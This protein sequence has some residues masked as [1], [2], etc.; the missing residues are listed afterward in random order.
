MSLDARSDPHTVYATVLRG[1]GLT[2]SELPPPHDGEGEVTPEGVGR[3][4]VAAGTTDPY[5]RLLES[6]AHSE[7]GVAA[8]RHYWSEAP[9]QHLGPVLSAFGYEFGLKTKPD[10]DGRTVAAVLRTDATVQRTTFTYPED[11]DG[12]D[13]YP[14]LVHAI[15]QR[16][17]P[18]AGPTFVRLADDGDAW[19]FAL[20]ERWRLAELQER[21]GDRI[22]VFGE[23]LLAA[24][25]P[26]D[27]AGEGDRPGDVGTVSVPTAPLDDAFEQ[28]R[29]DAVTDPVAGAES[30][31]LGVDLDR[32]SSAALRSADAALSG[33][34]GADAT[35]GSADGS[36]ADG[37]D[38]DGDDTLWS[39]DE[40]DGTASERPRK[41]YAGPE[42]ADSGP[43]SE[44]VSDRGRFVPSDP[45]E[46]GLDA[47]PTGDTGTQESAGGTGDGG[48]GRHVADDADSVADLPE[49]VTLD[50]S[51]A[52]RARGE[53]VPFVADDPDATVLGDDID[54]GPL[55]DA[56]D[57]SGS[58]FGRQE[59]GEGDANDGA[60]TTDGASDSG[61]GP[62]GA[63]VAATDAG[64]DDG[65][66][67]A[68]TPLSQQV[69]STL[70]EGGDSSVTTAESASASES[71]TADATGTRDGAEDDS[72]SNEHVPR[73]WSGDDADTAER[74]DGDVL[75]A[76][77]EWIE[78]E[79]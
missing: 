74:A 54:D 45:P 18:E 16:L 52:T 51:H 2:R 13:A 9:A 22:E 10:G 14:A 3:D 8:P 70:N 29:R 48:S 37:A 60:A 73:E 72:V 50:R 63:A 23:P 77:T 25:Q 31:D 38:P 15:E 39:T 44:P 55:S 79:R 12:P 67:S 36:T 75:S 53:G 28:V 42:D 26:A 33:E 35:A 65:A 59:E 43:E 1:F 61:S 58:V 47:A 19:R 41:R 49:S 34:R 30:I 62:D 6:L 57:D 56:A 40:T 71:G 4:L 66:E 11:G 64:R 69:A 68:E 76:I 5:D 21:F 20:V 24:Y 7:H 32:E 78:E 46:M 17:L 27:L